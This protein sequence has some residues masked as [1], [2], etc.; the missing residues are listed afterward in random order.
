MKSARLTRDHRFLQAMHT[1]YIPSLWAPS[2]RR[3]VLHREIYLFG[4]LFKVDHLGNIF[5]VHCR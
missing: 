2:A 3:Q 1:L 4:T 5:I